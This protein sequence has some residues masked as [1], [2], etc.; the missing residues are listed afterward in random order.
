MDSMPKVSESEYYEYLGEVFPDDILSLYYLTN[1]HQFKGKLDSLHRQ[2]KFVLDDCG[3]PE[4]CESAVKELALFVQDANDLLDE[5][6]EKLETNYKLILGLEKIIDS[7]P[8][9]LFE[10]ETNSEH[11]G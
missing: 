8:D 4:Y 10:I 9:A 6:T 5:Y 11:T 3:V 7:A 2:S 1:D